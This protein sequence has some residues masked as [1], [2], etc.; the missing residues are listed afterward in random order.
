MTDATGPRYR[1]PASRSRRGPARHRAATPGGSRRLVLGGGVVAAAS[2]SSL[3]AAVLASR[4]DD[5]EDTE[6]AT[7][8]RLVDVH[9]HAMPPAVRGW[10]V[11][12]GLVPPVGGPPFTIWD[13]VSALAALDHNGIDLAV[14]SAAIPA[15]YAPDPYEA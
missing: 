10:M 2:V 9:H 14:L 1:V 8:P 11:N 6:P 7:L 13:P 15:A 3:G 5:T 12:R 4:Q